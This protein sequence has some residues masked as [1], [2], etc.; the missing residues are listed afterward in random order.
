MAIAVALSAIGLSVVLCV[1]SFKSVA[2]R[3]LLAMAGAAFAAGAFVEFKSASRFQ[4]QLARRDRYPID[5][6]AG[7][8]TIRIA[9]LEQVGAYGYVE[10]LPKGPPLELLQWKASP[11][12]SLEVEAEQGI[13]PEGSVPWLSVEYH[14][15]PAEWDLT[16]TV[17][18]DLDGR[19]EG[20]VLVVRHDSR[21]RHMIRDHALV[22]IELLAVACAVAATA[23]FV[24]VAV[25]IRVRRHAAPAAVKR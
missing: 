22:F 1:L 16:Y 3:I 10:G 19:F 20:A 23:C 15:E 24:T 2:A 17:P 18:P 5:A 14:G 12:G 21:S 4:A 9:P 25:A 6:S 8:H 11:P 13:D 7:K